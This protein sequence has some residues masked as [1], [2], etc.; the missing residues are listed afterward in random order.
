MSK[1]VK[2]MTA[3]GTTLLLLVSCNKQESSDLRLD[4][5]SDRFILVD[6][7]GIKCG[8][9]TE[10]SLA[11]RFIRSSSFELKWFQRDR[12]LELQTIRVELTGKDLTTPFKYTFSATELTAM[13]P[14]GLIFDVNKLPPP[15]ENQEDRT[16]SLKVA[17]CRFQV[18]GISILDEN[19]SGT[20]TG[21][22]VM[23]GY[24]T[25]VD[26]EDLRSFRADKDISVEYD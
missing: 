14:M 22:I 11:A 23:K 19:A 24:T 26:G 8:S 17:G 20:L 2:A 9:T 12:K 6:A 13:F 1:Y 15:S 5:S 16:D 18:G 10:G 21:R 25:D 4:I 7:T 3:L